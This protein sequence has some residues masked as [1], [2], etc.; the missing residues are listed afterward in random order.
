[1]STNINPGNLGNVIASIAIRKAIYSAYIIAGIVIGATQVAFASIEGAG[2]PTWLTVTLAVYAFLSVPIGSL[3]ISNT[4]SSL[5]EAIATV[6]EAEAEP[7][8][9]GNDLH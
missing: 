5:P 2:Q 6:E 1:M 4:P 3:A 7:A 8:L 9:D